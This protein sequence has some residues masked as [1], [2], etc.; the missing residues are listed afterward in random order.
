MLSEACMKTEKNPGKC[1]L[2]A[3]DKEKEYPGE[4]NQ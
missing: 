1:L 3:L 4:Q 2:Y